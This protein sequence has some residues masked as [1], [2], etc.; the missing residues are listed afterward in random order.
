M[1]VAERKVGNAGNWTSETGCRRIGVS[2]YRRRSRT[3][4][5]DYTVDGD[6]G[7]ATAGSVFL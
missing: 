6:G 3:S 7:P 4:W 2:A 1:N 5:V